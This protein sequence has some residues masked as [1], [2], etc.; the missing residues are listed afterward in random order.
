ME[1]AKYFVVDYDVLIAEDLTEQGLITYAYEKWLEDSDVKDDFEEPDDLVTALE[2][3][4][5][6]YKVIKGEYIWIK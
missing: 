2:Y 3:L 5:Y 1:T 6:Y 4:D